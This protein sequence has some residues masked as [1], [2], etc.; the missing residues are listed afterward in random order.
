MVVQ[1][2]TFR[3]KDSSLNCSIA[4][5]NDLKDLLLANESNNDLS[6]VKAMSSG[7]LT[8]SHQPCTELTQ[9][10][11]TSKQDIGIQVTLEDVDD[12]RLSYY[13]K[14]SEK[15]SKINSNL[16]Q[17][18][19]CLQEKNCRD[20]TAYEDSL[21]YL[22]LELEKNQLLIDKLNKKIHN[23]GRYC[24]VSRQIGIR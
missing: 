24:K 3:K 18:I 4:M 8:G 13:T 2:P 10:D 15:L 11:K 14:K 16:V 12:N 23:L 17:D 9:S 22:K 5:L 1:T 19:N 6:R 20:K 21:S 7:E